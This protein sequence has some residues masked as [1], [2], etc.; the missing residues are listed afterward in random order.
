MMA[1]GAV[2][3]LGQDARDGRKVAENVERRVMARGVPNQEVLDERVDEQLNHWRLALATTPVEDGRDG[4][5][6]VPSPRVSAT[7]EG[8]G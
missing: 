1:P 7:R 6:R 5:A 4:T 2:R 8:S 3:Q